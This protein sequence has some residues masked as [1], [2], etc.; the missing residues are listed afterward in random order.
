MDEKI[1]LDYFMKFYSIHTM[2]NN[3][4]TNTTDQTIQND[5]LNNQP[6]TNDNKNENNIIDNTVNNGSNNELTTKTTSK[7]NMNDNENII[8][9]SEKQHSDINANK[10]LQKKQEAQKNQVPVSMWPYLPKQEVEK[11]LNN[12][13]QQELKQIRA[14]LKQQQKQDIIASIIMAILFA[15][16]LVIAAIFFP[17]LAFLAAAL[18]VVSLATGI[19]SAKTIENFIDKINAK[20]PT[21]QRELDRRGNSRSNISK[22]NDPKKVNSEN[23]D[24]KGSNAETQGNTDNINNS[25]LKDQDNTNNINNK[26]IKNNINNNTSKKQEQSNNNTSKKQE[27]SNDNAISK[28]ILADKKIN[29]NDIKNHNS[30]VNNKKINTNE[31][32]DIKTEKTEINTKN[33]LNN[34]SN[35]SVTQAC[36]IK[37]DNEAANLIYL[38]TAEQ[39][40]NGTLDL[41]SRPKD[42]N[43]YNQ[44]K[45]LFNK[46]DVNPR[47][48]AHTQLQ[49]IK[50][51]IWNQLPQETQQECER[52]IEQNKSP[53]G[54]L[55]NNA[56]WQVNLYN[57][58][59]E[60]E[61]KKNQSFLGAIWNALKF[62]KNLEEKRK[63][64]AT[65]ILK[66]SQQKNGIKLS[67]VSQYTGDNYSHGA[68][69]NKNMKI[70]VNQ[71]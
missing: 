53:E 12:K 51:E 67:S 30:D 45:K 43:E 18:V 20:I 68:I 22:I 48:K 2:K 60:N 39:V 49:M 23:L 8:D 31:K 50:Y 16:I 24:K 34:K 17:P 15:I 21:K 61:E 64:V 28:N 32:T 41:S 6:T 19:V 42:E 57:K 14:Q 13:N 36:E 70:K 7:Q 40:L 58:H 63:A 1:Y 9:N 46:K 11:I 54:I 69:T 27:Q 10:L 35:N 38:Q 47:I 4:T 71:K 62:E 5:V 37:D 55:K 56:N 52:L 44:F 29:S 26:N 65:A 59:L 3:N 33:I 66:G 25:I